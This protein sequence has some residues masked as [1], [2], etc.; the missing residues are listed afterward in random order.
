MGQLQVIPHSA[1]QTS[2]TVHKQSQSLELLLQHPDERVQAIELA[3]FQAEL[4]VEKAIN[5]GL[6]IRAGVLADKLS[7]GEQIISLLTHLRN[8]FNI[9]KNLD[10]VQVASATMLIMSEFP[11][12]TLDELAL[13]FR[14]AALGRYG[15]SYDSLDVSIVCRFIRQYVDNEREAYFEKLHTSKKKSQLTDFQTDIQDTEQGEQFLKTCQE[16]VKEVLDKPKPQKEKLQVR[17]LTEEEY[18]SKLTTSLSVFPDKELVEFFCEYTSKNWVQGVDIVAN[19][20]EKR[21]LTNDYVESVI[22]S[23]RIESEKQKAEIQKKYGKKS[24]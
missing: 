19:E 21:Q 10:D 7:T 9:G 2:L 20:M 17:S 14:N 22:R 24:E 6:Q 5:S 18:L 13:V 3:K 8:Q 1:N 15:K 4:T 23:W 12:L 16:A 11:S